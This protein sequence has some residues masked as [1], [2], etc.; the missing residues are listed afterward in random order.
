MKMRR[1]KLGLYSVVAII[2]KVISRLNRMKN[3]DIHL[4]FYNINCE[5]IK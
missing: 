5:D 4:F 3:I 1:N 2:I